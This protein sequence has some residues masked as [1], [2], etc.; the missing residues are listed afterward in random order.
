MI[1]SDLLGVRLNDIPPQQA[2]E[3]ILSY[4]GSLTA[5]YVVTVN[6]E[7]LMAGMEKK[8]FQD[9]LNRSDLALSDGIGIAWA[10]EFFQKIPNWLPYMPKPLYRRCFIRW[11]WCASLVRFAFLSMTHHKRDL[12]RT[13]GSDLLITL[14]KECHSS[15]GVFLVGARAGVASLAKTKLLDRFKHLSIVGAQAGLSFIRIAQTGIQY[16]KFE[17]ERLVEQIRRASPSIV[18]VAFGQIKQEAWITEHLF[19]FPSVKVFIGV[20]GT[21][22][23]IA[24]TTRRSPLFL[25]KVGL[26]WLWR[27][28]VE[29][30][31]IVRIWTA[32]VR[33]PRAVLAQA[34]QEVE[35]LSHG[36]VA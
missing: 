5:R 32:V 33:F 10:R 9:L 34:Q 31:R 12:E 7:F 16:D 19:Q 4:L 6:P 13:A 17:N 18:A 22:D 8:W 15:Q 1:F 11:I 24:G 29:P 21:L 36:S 25:Q 20:G 35:Q 28:M 2:V 14:L 30:K 23:F 27:L 26:E 3:T